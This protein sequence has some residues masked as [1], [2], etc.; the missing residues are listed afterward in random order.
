MQSA[1]SLHSWI[2]RA[3]WCYSEILV[4]LGRFILKAASLD[5]E[6]SAGKR[7]LLDGTMWDEAAEARLMR[8][9]V[10]KVVC[11]SLWLSQKAALC[12]EL[13]SMD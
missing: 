7:A 9:G 10:A 2:E 5:E 1:T 12:P 11:V 13:G 4:V 3:V 8:F 6:R